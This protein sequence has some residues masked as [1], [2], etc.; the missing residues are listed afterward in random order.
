M[1]SKRIY[2]DSSAYLANLLDEKSGATVRSLVNDSII[3]S[4]ALLILEA[5]RTITLLARNRKITVSEHRDLMN[6]L[7]EDC[8]SMILRDVGL[9]LCLHGLFPS[10]KTPRS[11]DLAH[12]RA[13]K[14]FQNNGGLQQFITLDEHQKEAAVEMGLPI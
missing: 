8:E 2:L 13:A 7:E 6:Q 10:I 12:L 3:C 14:W 1:D 11:L 4:S 9:D 5:E